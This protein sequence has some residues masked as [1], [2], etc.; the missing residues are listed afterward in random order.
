MYCCTMSVRIKVFKFNW[1]HYL[2][3]KG[4]NTIRGKKL[5]AWFRVIQFLLF[6]MN[7]EGSQTWFWEKES[8]S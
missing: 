1:N 5:G 8:I 2:L 4:S 6:L 3:G 7:L